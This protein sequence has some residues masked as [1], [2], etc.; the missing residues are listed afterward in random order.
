MSEGATQFIGTEQV[1][2]LRERLDGVLAMSDGLEMVDAAIRVI[3]EAADVLEVVERHWTPKKPIRAYMRQLVCTR[4]EDENIRQN[5][6]A[7]MVSLPAQ[8]VGPEQAPE[9]LKTLLGQS[10]ITGD[11][12]L[13]IAALAR[14]ERFERR[15][16]EGE[17]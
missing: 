15:R 16:A 8:R 9:L 6:V 10:Q 3:A 2:S 1:R 5:Q 4:F 13:K 14:R 11:D 7:R 17:S 12:V